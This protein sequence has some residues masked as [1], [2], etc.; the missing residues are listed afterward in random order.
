LPIY[1]SHIFY[2]ILG[3]L[4][5]IALVSLTLG[6]DLYL[7]VPPNLTTFALIHF[8]GY[9]FFLLMPVELLY[10]YYLAEF[11]DK[12]SLTI[13][14]LITAVMA[15]IVDYYCGYLIR[16]HFIGVIISRKKYL[17]SR[18]ILKRYGNASMFFF[19]L[20]PLSSPILI[21][22]AASLRYRLVDVLKYSIPALMIKYL[23]IAL[24]FA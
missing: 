10:I 3:I 2:A 12:I 4:C 16:H 22:V 20:F 21:F 8:G 13:V 7:G 1:K 24:M 23:T 11:S 15:Q 9:L 19:N 14:A 17:K 18:M 5:V 6:R